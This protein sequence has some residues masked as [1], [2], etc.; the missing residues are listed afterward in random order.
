MSQLAYET[1]LWKALALSARVHPQ[2][3]ADDAFTLGRSLLRGIDDQLTINAVR[4]FQ[5]RCLLTIFHLGIGPEG[6]LVTI[7][8]SDGW[9][10][11]ESIS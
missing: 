11:A 8:T 3:V 10:A 5:S 1:D 2:G 7:L 9:K 6:T 4:D